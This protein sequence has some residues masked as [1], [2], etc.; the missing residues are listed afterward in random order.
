MASWLG[1]C[2]RLSPKAP[3]CLHP[4]LPVQPLILVRMT[5]RPCLFCRGAS[6]RSSS[7][8][9]HAPERRAS[10]ADELSGG[11]CG[12]S[13]VGAPA[14][15]GG[16]HPRGQQPGGSVHLQRG[17]R[18]AALHAAI[19]GEMVAL[20]IHPAMSCQ[21][22]PFPHWIAFGLMHPSTEVQQAILVHPLG[23]LANYRRLKLC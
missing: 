22:V 18:Q 1:V 9:R 8:G 10:R 13:A 17:S 12:G 6:S 2:S 5:P 19:C 4:A 21:A 14:A 7:L 3:P 23:A 16:R 20:F 15:G 11:R